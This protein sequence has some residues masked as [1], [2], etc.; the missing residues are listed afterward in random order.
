MATYNLR[1]LHSSKAATVINGQEVTGTEALWHLVRV[2]K[3]KFQYLLYR[4]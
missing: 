3:K 4:R 2:E 1:Y